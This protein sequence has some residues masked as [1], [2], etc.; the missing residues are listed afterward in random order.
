VGGGGRAGGGGGGGGGGEGEGEKRAR[1]LPPAPAPLTEMLVLGG[2]SKGGE[3]GLRA[4][5]A[6]EWKQEQ[7][8][9][10]K[11]KL[12]ITYSYWDG[13]GHRRSLEVPRGATVGRFLRWVH[14]DLQ[15]EFPEL[16]KTAPDDLMFVKEDLILPTH[17]SFHDL[18]ALNARG[19]TGPLFDFG[20]SAEH[21]QAMTSG[22]QEA[23]AG[24]VVDRR[25]YERN[26]HLFPASRWEPFDLEGALKTAGVAHSTE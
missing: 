25:W 24:K 14:E 6:E 1:K 5:F 23:H 8:R 15:P 20:V 4:R 2:S 7:E 18:I 11:L 21:V 3:E 10:K 19:K 12:K 9:L 26:K 17:V 22:E 16:R 13:S